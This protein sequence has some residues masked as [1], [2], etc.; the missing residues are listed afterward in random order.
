MDV[1]GQ[2]LKAGRHGEAG[3]EPFGQLFTPGTVVSAK[4]PFVEVCRFGGEGKDLGR[5]SFTNG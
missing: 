3:R 5:V 2:K 1:V 4:L